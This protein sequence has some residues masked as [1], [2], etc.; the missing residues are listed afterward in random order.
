[1]TEPN[2]QA[3]QET[4][5]AEK[6]ATETASRRLPALLAAIIAMV[7]W[8]ILIFSNGYLA[9]AV[10]AVAAVIGFVAAR[11]GWKSLATAAIIASLVLIV[12][13]GA[14]L[15]IIKFVL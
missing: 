11:K 14:F 3:A 12:V 4:P 6:P 5:I 8:A 13:T 15:I 9:I 7:A 2:T 1:M 10:A